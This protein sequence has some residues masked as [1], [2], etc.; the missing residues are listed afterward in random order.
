[1][2]DIISGAKKLIHEQVA[3]DGIYYESGFHQYGKAYFWTNE[4]IRGYLNMVDLGGKDNALSVLASGDH[5]YN[6]ITKGITNIDTFDTNKLTEFYALELK[7]AIILKYN[8]EQYFSFMQLLCSKL[9][10]IDILT[11][12]IKGLFS[13]MSQRGEMFWNA[14]LDYNYYIQ[15]E[16]STHFNLIHLW[17]VNERLQ[18][19]RRNNYLISKEEY[20]K[21]RK[22]LASVNITFRHADAIALSDIFKGKY[23]VIMLSNILDYFDK[24][25]GNC[26]TYDSLVQYEEKLRKIAKEDAIIFL[27]YIFYYNTYKSELISNTSIY[28]RNLKDEDLLPIYG[29]HDAILLQR[30]K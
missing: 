17:C 23:D 2:E 25:F 11:D 20:E 7:R 14:I 6:L 13:Y 28:A 30:I 19:D 21:L 29:T 5:A 24:Y 15:K 26:W 9:I 8:Y 4:N 12:L 27:N 10:S 3:V 18:F 1:M 16:H 22:S